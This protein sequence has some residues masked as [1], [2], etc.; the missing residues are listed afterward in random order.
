[1]VWGRRQPKGCLLYFTSDGCF[2]TASLFCLHSLNSYQLP[3]LGILASIGIFV[4]L[5]REA[6][7]RKWGLF[8]L[9]VSL[10]SFVIISQ[11]AWLGGKIRHCEIAGNVTQNQ[12]QG[13]VHDEED[14]D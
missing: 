4:S 3:G 11:T 1:M 9:V 7:Q 14:D 13:S 12:G 2:K 8:M 5:S 10:F 6:L